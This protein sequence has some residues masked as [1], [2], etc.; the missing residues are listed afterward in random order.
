M[1]KHKQ[2]SSIPIILAIGGGLLLIVSAIMLAIQNAP[3]ALPPVTAFSLQA[4]SGFL[5]CGLDTPLA[6][7]TRGCPATNV[8]FRRASTSLASSR[9]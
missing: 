5:Y 9:R 1:S 3:A 8:Q 2:N 4:A 6:K 7:N